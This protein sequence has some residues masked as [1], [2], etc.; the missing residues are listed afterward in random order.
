MTNIHLFSS[1]YVN[2]NKRPIL[3]LSKAEQEKKQD[4]IDWSTFD[5]ETAKTGQ[6]IQYAQA[7]DIPLEGLTTRTAAVKVLEQIK[8]FNVAKLA[9]EEA[10]RLAKEKADAT[11]D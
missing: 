7:H 10:E 1:E 6:L 2:R 3:F 5:L 11:T 8:A 9:A 4:D